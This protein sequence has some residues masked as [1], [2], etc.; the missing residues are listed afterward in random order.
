MQTFRSLVLD[1]ALALCVIVAGNASGQ[2]AKTGTAE[3]KNA[4]PALK[5][6]PPEIRFNS[7]EGTATVSVLLGDTPVKVTDIK[8]AAMAEKAWMFKVT[9]S[10]KDPATVT[11]STLPDKVEDGS[12]RLAVKAAGQMA[13]ADVY[14]TLTPTV[15]TSALLFLPPRLELDGSYKKGTTLTYRIEA[16]MDLHYVWTINGNVVQQGPGETKL[17]YTFKDAGPC[18]IGLTIKQGDKTLGHSEGKT[19]VTQ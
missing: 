17:V 9:K 18:T 11:V 5:L 1:A 19:E 4:A 13:Y 10:A 2:P 15:S 12:Y 8:S 7:T 16:P 14:V 3:S 6:A